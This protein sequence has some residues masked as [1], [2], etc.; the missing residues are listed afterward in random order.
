M[1]ATYDK[2]TARIILDKKL[3]LFSLRSGT[4]KGCPFSSLLFNTVLEFLATAIKEEKTKRI[5]I[6]KEVKLSL[7]TDDM[8]LYIENP[9][10]A[11]IKLLELINE[12]K[13]VARYIINI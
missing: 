7:L 13:K 6:G 8:T 5:Q 10:D 9:K 11:T 1:K 12:F 3:E 4:R 2:P